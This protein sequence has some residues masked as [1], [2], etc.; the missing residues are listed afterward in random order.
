M[1]MDLTFSAD[2]V[3]VVFHDFYVNPKLCWHPKQGVDFKP[4]A[5]RHLTMQQLR[6]YE[7][8]SILKVD[9]PEQR[10]VANAFILSFE[11]V[12]QWAEKQP[13]N[14]GLNIEIKVPK[15]PWYR[16]KSYSPSLITDKTLELI[17]KYNLHSRS[18]IQAFDFR[19]LERVRVKAPDIHVGYLFRHDQ[20]FV[21]QGLKLKAKYLRPRFSLVTKEKIEKAHQH[22]MKV[23]SWTVNEPKEWDR[24]IEIGV[25]GII[26][27]Y[28]RKLIEHLVD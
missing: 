14:F 9:F 20:D 5:V 27:D 7:C 19:V 11:E 6:G 13:G 2:D 22:G 17:D 1:E 28:P 12:C 24:L 3:P 26:T 10:A 21:E 15:N 8:G 16:R 18:E 25:E 4:V 23:A